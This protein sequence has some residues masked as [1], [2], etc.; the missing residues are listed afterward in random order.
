MSCAALKIS[1]DRVVFSA[2][3]WTLCARTRGVDRR[4]RRG[5][6]RGFRD[7]EFRRAERR[8]RGEHR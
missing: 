8:R 6:R 2:G 7:D 3:A 4:A 1:L 5:R